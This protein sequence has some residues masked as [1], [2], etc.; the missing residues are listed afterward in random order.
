MYGLAFAIGCR[1]WKRLKGTG[2]PVQELPD[3]VRA[4][5]L[6]TLGQPLVGMPDVVAGLDW[7]DVFPAREV[8][9]KVF[10]DRLALFAQPVD[11]AP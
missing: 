5:W 2:S 9:Q 1:L 10:I 7:I 8:G 4:W 6:S 3:S 11:S